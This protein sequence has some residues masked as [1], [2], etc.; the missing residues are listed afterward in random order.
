MSKL[1]EAVVQADLPVLVEGFDAGL[2]KL[3]DVVIESSKDDTFNDII[4]LERYLTFTDDGHTRRRR[5]W[6]MYAAQWQLLIV[7]QGSSVE[8]FDYW[9]AMANYCFSSFELPQELWFATDPELR[10]RFPGELDGGSPDP[11]QDGAPADTDGEQ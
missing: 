7:Y 3:A 9:E 5:M 1:P 8:E 2:G 4:R 6:A 11:E 10:A